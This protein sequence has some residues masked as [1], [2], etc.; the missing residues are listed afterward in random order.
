MTDE[1]VGRLHVAVED[2]AAVDLE[3]AE[4]E[5]L[6]NIEYNRYNDN[7]LRPHIIIDGEILNVNE[8]INQPDQ[9]VM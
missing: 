5:V 2:L 6:K 7:L 1:H 9:P 8:S 3:E 4:Q